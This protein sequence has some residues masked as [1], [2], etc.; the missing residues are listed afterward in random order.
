LQSL[1]KI[2][3]KTALLEELPSNLMAKLFQPHNFAQDKPTS[4][5]LRLPRGAGARHTDSQAQISRAVMQTNIQWTDAE[6]SHNKVTR[7]FRI[8]R[9]DSR[10][11]TGA[12][13]LPQS[14]VEGKTL[15]CCGHG[16]S[17]DR[18]QAPISHLAE[19]FV[20][21][22]FPVLSLDGPVHGLRKVGD[23]GRKAFF[24]EYQRDNSLVD[25]TNEWA[26]A[27]EQIKA[28]TGAGNLA[29]FGLSMGSLFGIPFIASR[30]DVTVAAIGL[31][32]VQPDFPHGETL[33]ENAA[34]IKCPI[35]FL[36]QLE[37]ELF[38]RQGCL[39]VFDAFA[40]K[41]KRLH[42]N[43][44][45]HPEVPAEEIDFTFEFMLAHINGTQTKKIVNIISN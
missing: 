15:I 14:S 40:S 38:N 1:Q 34:Q 44:G 9:A 27:V 26:F 16:A 2:T 18:Y 25:M 7:E 23:G 11:I 24:P 36:M 41:D 12:L 4:L 43:P 32:G 30:T 33:L 39:D 31:M 3:A 35:L 37:D 20:D 22:G 17:G 10:D 8:Q 5:A 19:R 45:L 42:A 13:W 6:D 29:Y 28:A 21:A